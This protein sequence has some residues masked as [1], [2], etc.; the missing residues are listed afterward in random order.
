MNDRT[1]SPASAKVPTLDGL[2]AVSVVLVFL[3]HAGWGRFI[4]GSFG[5]TVFFFLSGYLITTLFRQEFAQTGT[6]HIGHFY[7]RRLIRLGPPLLIVLAL[8]GMCSWLGIPRPADVTVGS[9]AAQLL[10]FT[11]YYILLFGMEHLLPGTGIL[12]SLAVEEHYYLVY[13]VVLLVLLRRTD[14]QSIAWLLAAACLAT[15][16]W[17]YALLRWWGAG[18]EWLSLATDTRIDSI[19]F[20][21]LLALAHNPA[22]DKMPAFGS[23][24]AVT[25]LGAATLVFLLVNRS[26]AGQAWQPALRYSLQGLWLAAVFWTAISFSQSWPFAWLSWPPLERLGQYSYTF[27]LSHLLVLDVVG[28]HLS[29]PWTRAGVAFGMTLGF[30]ALV[31]QWVELPLTRWRRALRHSA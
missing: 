24:T 20:G 17:R 6:L 13:P 16:A 7:L 5:V 4:P 1:S 11:N 14:R 27:Y 8:A 25:A 12:W 23:L 28:S 9:V 10:Y 21:S 19:L 22:M 15:L 3:A 31:H 18:D 29:D 26:L 30:S 2:R